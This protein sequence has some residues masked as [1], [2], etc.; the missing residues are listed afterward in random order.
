MKQRKIRKQF[1]FIGGHKI[2]AHM[3]RVKPLR[4]MRWVNNELVY[5]RKTPFK[6]KQIMK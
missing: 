3:R 6:Y 4:G 5:R 2:K 1:W